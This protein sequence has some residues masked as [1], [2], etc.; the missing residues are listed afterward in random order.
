MDGEP[1]RLDPISTTSLGPRPTDLLS[2]ITDYARLGSQIP[3]F[4]NSGETI[5]STPYM[6]NLSFIADYDFPP[7]RLWYRVVD[8]QVWAGRQAV[9][10]DVLDD[11]GSSRARLWL[12]SLTGITLRE[13]FF[14]FGSDGDVLLES[15]VSRIDF[16]VDFHQIYIQCGSEFNY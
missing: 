2:G 3:W 13:Q 6:L 11:N 9:I 14:G 8:Q 1:E 7:Y 15:N 16:D 4:Y 10:V 12:D 5:V